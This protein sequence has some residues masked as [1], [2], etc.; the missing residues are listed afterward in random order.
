[1]RYFYLN[2]Y[3]KSFSNYSL[4]KSVFKIPFKIFLVWHV[5]YKKCFCMVLDVFMVIQIAEKYLKKFLKVYLEP[6]DQNM[7]KC[8]AIKVTE[9]LIFLLKNGFKY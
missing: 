1:M 2:L 7:K 5:F 3:F 9:V 8:I 6:F 4:K